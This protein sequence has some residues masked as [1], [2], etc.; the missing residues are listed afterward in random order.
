MPDIHS[1]DIVVG[2]NIAAFRAV[3]GLTQT[4]LGRAIGVTFQQVQKYESGRNRL[5]ASKLHQIAAALDIQV[6]DLFPEAGAPPTDGAVM[7]PAG[8]R[9]INAL[10]KLTPTEIAAL[11]DG[12][13]TLG[14]GR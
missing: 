2:K 4:Q 7:T 13:R 5:S 6:G 1:V 11:A 14:A 12:A 9:L 3:K 8:R 10:D